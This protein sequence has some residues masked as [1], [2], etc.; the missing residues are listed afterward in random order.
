MSVSQVAAAGRATRSRV[1]RVLPRHLWCLLPFL[2]ACAGQTVRTQP[3]PQTT[4]QTVTLQ[5]RLHVVW[6]HAPRY[7]LIDSEGRST[8]LAME[9]GQIEALGGPLSV[10][11]RL[12]AVR[13]TIADAATGVLRVETLEIRK[14]APP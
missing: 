5:G 3:T 6:N 9:P 13:G 1:P 4:G 2:I 11:G 8:E 14:E 10:D 7:F 12:V